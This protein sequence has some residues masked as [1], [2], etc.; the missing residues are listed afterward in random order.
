[1]SVSSGA[2]RCAVESN[3][4]VGDDDDDDGDD[5]DDDGGITIIPGSI[6]IRV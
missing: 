6:V 3:A 4:V 2:G 5:D 1:L